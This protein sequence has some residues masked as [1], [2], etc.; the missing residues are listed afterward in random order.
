MASPA[1]AA[2]LLQRGTVCVVGPVM[3]HPDYQGRGLARTL[4]DGLMPLFEAGKFGFVGLWTH[5]HSPLHVRLYEQYGFV[6]QKITSIMSKAPAVPAAGQA[7][8]NVSGLRFSEMDKAGQTR[9]LAGARA[10]AET[11]YPGFDLN[12]EINSTQEGGLGDTLFLDE[13]GRITGF[14]C[15]HHGEG[16]EATRNQLLVKFAAVAAGRGAA[17]NFRRLLDVCDAYAHQLGAERLIAGTNTGRAGAYRLMQRHGF[18]TDANGIAMMRP[19]TEGYNRPDVF[20][21]DD[22]R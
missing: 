6:M 21:I 10:V 4:M 14:A 19:S 17:D 11:L 15:C 12:G 8:S 22:W 1:G 7:G 3:V 20:A 16:S 5:V 9:A 13:G 2:V 18:R